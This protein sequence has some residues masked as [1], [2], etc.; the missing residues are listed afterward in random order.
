MNG[1]SY[2]AL[3]IAL[4]TGVII[5]ILLPFYP[6]VLDLS[7]VL[8]RGNEQ[9]KYIEELEV[10][11]REGLI[12]YE[13]EA[14]AQLLAAIHDGLPSTKY[15]FGKNKYSVYNQKKWWPPLYEAAINSGNVEV[16]KYFLEK[17]YD[18]HYRNSNQGLPAFKSAADSD[19]PVFFNLLVENNCVTEP[20]KFR[21][22]LKKLVTAS[23]YP[24]RVT[25]LE[26]KLEAVEQQPS[27]L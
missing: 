24:L 2:Y 15:V 5:L 9:V 3:R 13:S 20:A 14:K 25:L 18:C 11:K 6:E 22:D 7:G 27:S 8:K 19:N 12:P 16:F 26:Q 21:P 1:F 23:K 10:E 4:L 17:G